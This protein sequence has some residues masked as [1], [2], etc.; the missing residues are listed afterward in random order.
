MAALLY[1]SRDRFYALA[2][3]ADY[4]RTVRRDPKSE[5]ANC[6]VGVNK[7]PNSPFAAP[8]PADKP[9]AP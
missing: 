6:E 7:T 1:K 8:P 9:P 5:W 2:T 3:I 4:F